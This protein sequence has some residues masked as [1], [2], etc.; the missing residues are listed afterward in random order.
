MSDDAAAGEAPENVAT[1]L[2][3]LAGA[4]KAGLFATFGG[5][6]YPYLAELRA[7]YGQE[8]AGAFIKP[9]VAALE[10][11]AASD[12]AVAANA[13]PEGFALGDWCAPPPRP[14]CPAP[15]LARKQ[16]RKPGGA[17]PALLTQFVR[18]L[19]RLE[20]TEEPSANYLASASV[21]YPLVGLTQLSHYVATLDKVG[22][23]HEDMVPLFKG[24][25]GHSQVRRN[26]PN[27]YM[28]PRHSSQFPAVLTTQRARDG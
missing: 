17:P 16:R 24:A 19:S 27:E 7:L 11:A 25:T 22:K 23:T 3:D 21:S 2:L 5:Q 6:G 12:E 26:S 18:R 15:H 28:R 14:R 4:G 1:G 10:A 13:H 20:G 9:I 8:A